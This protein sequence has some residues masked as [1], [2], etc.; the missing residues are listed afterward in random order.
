MSR[1]RECRQERPQWTSGQRRHGRCVCA[2]AFTLPPASPPPALP[3]VRARMQTLGGF[4]KY[5]SV[6]RF[7]H[8]GFSRSAAGCGSAVQCDAVQCD[9]MCLLRRGRRP[10][11]TRCQRRRGRAWPTRPG[12]RC[13]CAAVETVPPTVLLEVALV[14]AQSGVRSL[15]WGAL[16]RNGLRCRPPWHEWS[17]WTRRQGWCCRPHRPSR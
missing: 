11:R 15:P 5:D 10:W 2:R 16:G 12:R 9:A 7:G 13:R 6:D 14:H 8:I 1:Q 17:R 3:H 4:C